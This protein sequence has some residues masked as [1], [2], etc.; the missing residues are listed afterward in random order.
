MRKAALLLCLTCFS[1]ISHSQINPPNITAPSA[2]VS[3]SKQGI[4][5]SNDMY[6]GKVN[7]ALP[8]LSYNM[9]GLGFPISLSYNGGNG[10]KPDEL[11]SWVGLGWNLQVGG[12]IHRTVRGKADELRDIRQEQTV[13]ASTTGNVAS[14]RKSKTELITQDYSY[15][16]NL[17]NLNNANWYTQVFSNNLRSNQT[18]STYPIEI[19]HDV[20]DM[21]YSENITIVNN[22]PITDAAPDEFTF[23]A[24]GISGKFYKN[25]ANKWIVLSEDNRSFTVEMFIGEDIVLRSNGVNVAEYVYKIPR[26]IKRITLTSNDG[27]KYFFGTEDVNAPHNEQVYEYSRTSGLPFPEN[28]NVHSSYNSLVPSELN[29]LDII[30]HT[31]HLTKI[32]NIYNNT[33]L[34][35]D[36]TCPGYQFYDS[37]QAWGNS[38]GINYKEESIFGSSQDLALPTL[39]KLSPYSRIA[40]RIWLPTAINFSNGTKIKLNASPSRQLFA[41][42]LLSLFTSGPVFNDY[43]EMRWK[44]APNNLFKLDNIEVFNSGGVLTK[45]FVFRYSHLSTERL[46][47]SSI[48]EKSND[49]T[50]FIKQYQFDY[51]PTT[52]PDYGSGKVDHWGFYNNKNFFE[53]HRNV[54]F[55]YPLNLMRN[56]VSFREPDYNYTAAEILTKIIYPSG[57][58]VEFEYEP[59]QYAKTRNKLDLSI[60]N[61]G[62]DIAG[63]GV[64][65][66][67][68]TNKEFDGTIARKKSYIYKDPV[69]GLASGTMGFIVPSY[70]V[71][72]PGASVSW[73]FMARGYN[74]I[75]YRGA[76]VTYS[77]VTEKEDGNGSAIYTYS[78][79]DNGFND[80]L[81]V[82]Y[83]T[84][85]IT[86]FEYAYQNNA[87]KRGK[88]IGKTVKNEN[89]DILTQSTYKYQHDL[90]DASRNQNELRSVYFKEQGSNNFVYASVSDFLYNNYISESE[91]KYFSAGETASNKTKI[92]YNNEGGVKERSVENSDG[93]ISI[94]QMSYASDFSSVSAGDVLSK[95]LK[96]QIDKNCKG[97]LVETITIVQNANGTDS[98]VTGATLYTYD[99]NHL[100]VHKVFK[101]NLLEP[102]PLATFKK[103]AIVAGQLVVDNSYDLTAPNIINTRYDTY[104]NVLEQQL[105]SGV[106]QVTLWGYKGQYPIASITGSDYTTVSAVVTQA[107]IDAIP[108]SNATGLR[109]LLN[110]LRTDTRTKQAVITTATYNPLVGLTSETDAKGYTL[111]Y[112]YDGFGRLSAIRD[113]NNKIVKQQAYNYSNAYNAGK[114]FYNKEISGS[115]MKN[116]CLSGYRT[117]TTVIYNI[118]V[119]KYTSLVSQGDADEKAQND[120]EKNGQAYANNKSVC[121]KDCSL[122]ISPTYNTIFGNVNRPLVTDDNIT[123]KVAGFSLSVTSESTFKNWAKIGN[124]TGLCWPSSD[125]IVS[126]PGTSH[127]DPLVFDMKFKTNGEVDLILRSGKIDPFWREVKIKSFSVSF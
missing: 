42:N 7:V 10:I 53:T 64:R 5:I 30:S 122:S 80:K 47:L 79:F 91:D 54:Y 69:T 15:F 120:I 29:Y 1:I 101:L 72:T 118:P 49:G 98:K 86:S 63:G 105:P 78:N 51:N 46:K 99:I 65:L 67:S 66:K 117:F 3:L 114:V 88:L 57:G 6:N 18:K 20:E 84:D 123:F 14:L 102:I 38:I 24:P 97:S 73:V 34:T 56:Y 33:F 2:N 106:T 81:P 55:R 4:Q 25:Q 107:Q 71:E 12:Y 111:F 27:L 115:F 52:L 68:L 48:S 83:N 40:T 125:M 45:S 75:N 124:V 90:P 28:Q 36:Y 31:W 62:V 82:Q 96:N 103:A 100:Y 22:Y 70:L 39:T 95:G 35:I 44:S 112:Q 116:D 110:Q 16:N 89:G 61:K 74:S 127:F 50:E 92:Q 113:N 8:I 85:E 76:P 109:T 77:S 93:K 121:L 17:N 37:Y 41:D 11:P 60:E 21:G 43:L 119:G 19:T 126:V 59:N 94:E 23:V 104:G 87:F 32:E 58:A 13:I 26:T 108:T 9:N